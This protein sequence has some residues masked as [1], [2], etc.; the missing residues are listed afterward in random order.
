MEKTFP[1]IWCFSYA[2]GVKQIS[3]GQSQAMQSRGAAL[4]SKPFAIAVEGWIS[5]QSPRGRDRSKPRCVSASAKC[6][7]INTVA[8]G[9]EIRIRSN[10]GRRDSRFRSNHL[11]WADLCNAFGVKTQQKRNVKT[12][13]R[14][15]Q[16][17]AP[18]GRISPGT[19]KLVTL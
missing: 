3:P 16:A 14:T 4:G 12:S 19:Y 13:K 18:V 5:N 6:R 11:P 7:L 17:C 1:R 10:P 2:E 9:R 15:L 8:L